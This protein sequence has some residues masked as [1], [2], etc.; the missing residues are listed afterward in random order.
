MDRSQLLEAI[1]AIGGV[2]A[3][4]ESGQFYAIVV[5]DLPKVLTMIPNL[6]V[7]TDRRALRSRPLP[8]YQGGNCL[9]EQG[10]FRDN[11]DAE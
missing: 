3:S 11:L 9:A 6:E 7:G 4:L 8:W 5:L 10:I 2:K 1:K